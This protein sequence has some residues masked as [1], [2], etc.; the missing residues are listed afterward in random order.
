[1]LKIKNKNQKGGAALYFTFLIMIIFATI[2]I[3]MS[4]TFFRQLRAIGDIGFSVTAFYAADSGI[5]KILNSWANLGNTGNL[6][7][8]F[9]NVRHHVKDRVSY[10][11][12]KTPSQID[13]TKCYIKCIGTRENINRAIEVTRITTLT[14][15]GC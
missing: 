11:C 8:G 14:G 5:E 4:A 3:S 10:I 1:M 12:E 2:A 13:T 15:G 7:T 9:W 6:G